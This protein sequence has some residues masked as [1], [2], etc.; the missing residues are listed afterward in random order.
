MV[1]KWGSVWLQWNK[2]CKTSKT[3]MS[4]WKNCFTVKGLA[5][6]L[7]LGLSTRPLLSILLNLFPV[8]SLFTDHSKMFRSTDF[9]EICLDHM[10]M[11]GSHQK[12]QNII[13]KICFDH[14]RKVL[15]HAKNMFHWHLFFGSPQKYTLHSPVSSQSQFWSQM[16]M[17]QHTW[18]S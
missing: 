4:A 8:L 11:F 3:S 5:P 15:D 14:I 12:C 13:L 1:P 7:V 16:L 9:A 6:G 2:K 10:R 17:S 18:L